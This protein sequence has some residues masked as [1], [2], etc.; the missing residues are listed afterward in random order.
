MSKVS[1]TKPNTTNFTNF[2]ES[3]L[4]TILI[5]LVILIPIA[6]ATGA[7][8]TLLILPSKMD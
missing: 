1:E 5:L 6:V 2:L 4:H 8:F 3:H 7:V